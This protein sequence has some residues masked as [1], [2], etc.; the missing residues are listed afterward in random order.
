[1]ILTNTISSTVTL[2]SI[3]STVSTPADE[4]APVG[5]MPASNGESWVG[6]PGPTY[7]I[8]A[9]GVL[10]TSANCDCTLGSYFTVTGTAGDALAVTFN[11]GG[12]SGAFSPI[13][14]QVIKIRITA[15]GATV[16]TVDWTA[17]TITWIGS[18]TSTGGTSQVAPGTVS[19]CPLV[20]S[21]LCDV[22]LVCTGVNTF[23]GTF[24][25]GT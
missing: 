12:A 6:L 1:M 8:V 16:N 7:A 25:I 3:A 2:N 13:I 10:T 23:D 4:Q 21:K 24:I 18:K 5:F 9:L 17:N 15:S 20:A 14:G 11:T 19:T 22:T